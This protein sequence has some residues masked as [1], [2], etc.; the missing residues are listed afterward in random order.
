MATGPL[1]CDFA[2]LASPHPDGVLD[3]DDEDLAVADVSGAGTL[4]DRLHRP[5]GVGVLHNNL[6][7]Q[8]GQH[9]PRV[10]LAAAAAVD[11]PLLGASTG[12]VDDVQSDEASCLQGALNVVQL[13]WSDDR[14][15]LLHRA[16][17]PT[18]RRRL[19]APALS[20]S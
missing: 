3:R 1:Y 6:D 4:Q 11:N 10:G 14:F 20:M 16:L 12:D 18:R 2:S 9:V 19:M 17:L 5:F 13:L 7:L 15:D 8:L